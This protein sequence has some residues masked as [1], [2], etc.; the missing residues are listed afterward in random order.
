M[1]GLLPVA[2][3]QPPKPTLLVVDDTR[4]NLALMSSL[5]KED[6]H[7]KVAING[8]K[9]LRIAQ[10]DPPPDLIL[11]DVM[12]PG[13][14]GFEVCQRLKAESRTRRIPVIFLTA[15]SDAENEQKGLELGAVDYITK[16]ISPPILLARVK[17]HIALMTLADFLQKRNIELDLARA[18]A[19]K[20]NRAKSEF[21][22]SMSHELRSPLNAILGFS[23]LM[24]SDT[25]PPTA[26]QHESLTRIL[27]AGWHLL[28]LIDEI[29]DLA[30]VESGRVPLVQEA[31]P[32]GEVLAECLDMVAPQAQ[33]HG[34]HML[35][36]AFDQAQ[37]VRADRTRVKQVFIN[38]LTNAI[39][40]NSQS[41]S[42]T[43]ACA[44]TRA[45][46]I[47]VTITDTG[48]GLPSDQ[49]AQLFQPFNRL[50]QEG[51]REEGTGI[52]LVVAKRLVELMGGT[53][54]A[55]SAVGVGSEFWFDLPP[56]SEASSS[57][58]APV[59]AAAEAK[60]AQRARTCTLLYVEDNPSNLA[61]AKQIIARQPDLHLLTCG[62]GPAA[63]ESACASHPDLILM[64][65][66]LPGINGYEVLKLLRSIPAT[67]AIPVIALSANAMT[68]DI[69]RGLRAGFCRY[70]TKPFRI[71]DLMEAV[72]EVLDKTR[73]SLDEEEPHAEPV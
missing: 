56:A 11:L 36:P 15:K 39:K 20:A 26:S 58:P 59:P 33:E 27:Q 28:A 54:G 25:P 61:L 3:A 24:A 30:R 57:A 35:F 63:I 7:V 73:L 47:R 48:Q 45:G 44:R 68:L 34:V 50:G 1:T 42:V 52:G 5:L 55:S 51:G 41:G 6:Y 17:N 32:L 60:A 4:D 21:L 66:N 40:Y 37:I 8:E 71:F 43:V 53:I 9:A 38:L 46:Q 49:M 31:V 65:I 29:L 23:Q 22:S 67:A 19:E 2:S 10:S 72:N 64:D 16:P 18:A 62:D 70:L 69:E 13:L 14:D 12:M